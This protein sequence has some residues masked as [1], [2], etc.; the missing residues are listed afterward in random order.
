M[1]KI[2]CIDTSV[3]ACSVAISVD[4]KVVSYILENNKNKSAEI[5][6]NFIEKVC[7]DASILLNELDAIGIVSGPGSYTGLRIASS[8]AK[9]LCYG[10]N[11]PLIAISTFEAIREAVDMHFKEEKFEQYVF[12]IDARREDIFATIQD[13]YG[14]NIIEPGPFNLSEKSIFLDTIN[15]EKKIIIAGDA[16]IK[17]SRH[18]DYI[19]NNTIA[20]ELSYGAKDIAKSTLTKFLNK[21]FENIAYF[22][23]NY[24]KPA[25]TTV[26]KKSSNIW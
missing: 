9:G 26:S 8:T 17:T 12:A 7:K 21:N 10:L 18:L 16:A 20:D 3:Y 13:E 14:K 22:E 23:P 15:P 5:L 2:L 25:F 1:S 19:S 4:G 11:I 24:I 6:N